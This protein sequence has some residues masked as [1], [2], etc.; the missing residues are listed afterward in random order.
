MARKKNKPTEQDQL[1]A[2][3]RGTIF[4][5]GMSV[6]MAGITAYLVISLFSYDIHDPSFNNT[7]DGHVTNMGG[8][9]GAYLA[10]FLLQLFGYSAI[11]I[12]IFFGLTAFFAIRRSPSGL[13]WEQIGTLP[14]LAAVTTIL[15][16]MF[17]GEVI[18]YMPAGPGGLAGMMVTKALIQTLG[19]WGALLLLSTLGILSF[20]VLTRISLFNILS[21]FKEKIAGLLELMTSRPREAEQF[22]VAYA[23]YHDDSTAV[24]SDFR[25]T[26]IKANEIPAFRLHDLKIPEIPEASPRLIHPAETPVPEEMVADPSIPP[27]NDFDQHDTELAAAERP[28]NQGKL[29]APMAGLIVSSVGKVASLLRRPEK[30]M[31]NPDWLIPMGQD[32][33]PT[34]TI[35]E[36]K[37]P[38]LDDT[39]ATDRPYTKNFDTDFRTEAMTS[40]PGEIDVAPL[41]ASSPAHDP[42][43]DDFTATDAPLEEDTESEPETMTPPGPPSPVT[44]SDPNTSPSDSDKPGSWIIDALALK[45][46]NEPDPITADVT[47]SDAEITSQSAN[48]SERPQPDLTPFASSPSEGFRQPMFEDDEL[49]HSED[50][51]LDFSLPTL[52]D[53]KTQDQMIAEFE[54]EFDDRTL[55]VDSDIDDQ[56]FATTEPPSAETLANEE[57]LAAAFPLPP[58]DLLER[59]ASGINEIDRD[60]LTQQARLLEL[61]LADFKIKGQITNVQPGPVV[62]TYEFDPAPGL[63]A[64]KV[65]SISDDLARSILSPSV[66]VV[67]NIPGKNV[68][69]IEVPNQTRNTVYLREILESEAFIRT[70]HPLTVAMGSDITGSPVVANLAKMPHLLVAGTTGSGKSV[71]VNAMICSI[72]FSSRPDQV[73]FLMV[74][75]KMLE[76]SIYEG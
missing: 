35:D 25:T 55:A 68:I 38:A 42:L 23:G 3:L 41:S 43:A 60:Y 53:D 66:R 7:G 45:R 21:W 11:W 8:I 14:M 31:T 26:E 44:P 54:D 67:G 46:H 58:M 40:Q 33:D 24:A 48:L 32:L 62:T 5:E 47:V 20:M 36:K 30:E 10:D 56:E 75:P 39:D 29:F 12:P 17:Q 70:G 22:D 28:P 50:P 74:D 72:L 63:R 34:A 49:N 52:P 1:A 18:S 69:G 51:D 64:S 37:E 76:L 57:A 4:R 73:R 16:V 6:L 15:S 61:K 27:H 9:V 2:E 65:I 71:A 13:S 19:R 59:P